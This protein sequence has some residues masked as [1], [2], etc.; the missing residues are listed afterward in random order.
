MKPINPPQLNLLVALLTIVCGLSAHVR[1]QKSGSVPTAEKKEKDK[2]KEKP[3][4]AKPRRE[5]TPPPRRP[6]FRASNPNLELVLIAPGE[7]MMGSNRNEAGEQPVHRVAVTKA[8]YLGKYEV[9]QAQW[10]AVMGYNPS[11][12]KGDTRPV[13]QVSWDRAQLFLKALNEI[14]RRYVYRLPTEAEWEYAC[15]AGTT[16]DHAGDPS[17]LAWHAGNVDDEGARPVGQKQPNA[18]GLFDMHGNVRE[19]CA[20]WLDR[21]YYAVSPPADPRGP[22]TGEFR[23]LRGGSWQYHFKDASSSAR[24]GDI[25]QFRDEST[26]FR[27]AADKRN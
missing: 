15:R 11:R 6:G 13:E 10:Q 22:E 24:W 7:F 18:W 17:L 25:P 4:A 3:L 21:G 20:D 27:V 12:F 19:W 26:G 9:T 2:E 23:V 14:D 5:E 16:G 8:F 1:A